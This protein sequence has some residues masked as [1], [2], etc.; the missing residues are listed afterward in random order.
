MLIRAMEH[1]RTEHPDPWPLYRGSWRAVSFIHTT[2]DAE[3][4]SIFGCM[5]WSPH[6]MAL[7]LNTVVDYIK[8]PDRNSSCLFND[9]SRFGLEMCRGNIHQSCIALRQRLSHLWLLTH[10]TLQYIWTYADFC[11]FLKTVLILHP[12]FS[13]L[14]DTFLWYVG[15]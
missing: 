6:C 15:Q 9:C 12:F 2:G 3:P 10:I 7:F 11:R 4:R 14:T 1:H 5:R 8:A 13:C